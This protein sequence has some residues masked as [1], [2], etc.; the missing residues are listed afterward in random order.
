[1]PAKPAKAVDDSG[2]AALIAEL[3][4]NMR[5]QLEE[6]LPNDRATLDQIEDAAGKIGR[7][8]SQDIQRKLVEERGKHDKTTK[9]AC[10]C[11]RLAR[12][13]GEQPRTLVTAH[14]ALTYKRAC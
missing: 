3:L 5:R 7:K 10:P 9:A 6:Q 13:K 1:M 8:L 12:N 11:G 2:R 14:G 4:D